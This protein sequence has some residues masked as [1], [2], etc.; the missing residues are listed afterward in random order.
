MFVWS[1]GADKHPGQPGHAPGVSVRMPHG[2]K[3]C[4]VETVRAARVEPDD[5]QPTQAHTKEQSRLHKS[6]SGR[7]SVHCHPPSTGES[8]EES[9]GPRAD[10]EQPNSETLQND[11]KQNAAEKRRCTSRCPPKMF[12]SLFMSHA[13]KRACLRAC[14]G[15]ILAFARLIGAIHVVCACSHSQCEAA[16][17]RRPSNAQS[18]PSPHPTAAPRK[19]PQHQRYSTARAVRFSQPH[20]NRREPPNAFLRRPAEPRVSLQRGGF[21]QRDRF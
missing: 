4:D 10:R 15:I 7:L 18:R 21:L 13:E 19:R 11:D 2:R 6:S 1:R 9:H 5:D 14:A 8:R 17:V 20:R 12:P 3:A 16:S